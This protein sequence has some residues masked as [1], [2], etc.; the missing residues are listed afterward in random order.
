M[1][2]QEITKKYPSTFKLM[3]SINW[4]FFI[5]AVLTLVSCNKN[6]LRVQSDYISVEN[7]ASFHIGTPD[8]RMINPSVG[9]RLSLSWYFPQSYY[10][11]H[12]IKI[13]LKLHFG[14]HTLDELWISPEKAYGIYV[15]NLIN[16]DFFE[17]KGILTYKAEVFSNDV[18]VEEW[19]HQ[20]WV[21]LISFDSKEILID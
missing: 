2:I 16:Q 21:E 6:I 18:V 17:K 14:N 5:V 15:L 10:Y 4:I 19:V 3:Q 1:G 8:P 11:S 13:R 12:E 7:L 9:Q 20:L